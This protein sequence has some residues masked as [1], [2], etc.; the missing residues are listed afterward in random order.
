MRRPRAPLLL[1]AGAVAAVASPPPPDAPALVLQRFDAS[2]AATLAAAGGDADGP[3]PGDDGWFRR[4]YNGAG[5]L[6][7]EAAPA[8]AD[9]DEDEDEDE[10][11]GDGG[12]GPGGGRGG[13]GRLRIRYGAAQSEEW[14]GF[15]DVGRILVERNAVASAEDAAAAEDD[16]LGYASHLCDCRDA[17]AVRLTYRVVTPQTL[18]GRVHARE[19]ERS[20]R[21]AH[22]DG[23]RPHLGNLRAKGPH[24]GSKQ[25]QGCEV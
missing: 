12:D 1:A 14:G 23:G 4:A 18:P 6:R 19:S 15:V 3:G 17:A 9:A 7:F 8:D 11:G 25:C 16:D 22:A 13:R 10:S 5:H 21:G 20:S 2:L 24:L